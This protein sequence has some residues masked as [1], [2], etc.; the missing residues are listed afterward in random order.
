MKLDEIERR[1]RA[2]SQE[3]VIEVNQVWVGYV[4]EKPFRRV[5]ILAPHPDGGWIYQEMPAARKHIEVGHLGIVPEFNLRYVFELEQ[6][7]P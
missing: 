5:R 1:Q 2:R 4:R 3:P 6:T 7:N